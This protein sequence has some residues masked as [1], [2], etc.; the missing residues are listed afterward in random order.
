MHDLELKIDAKKCYDFFIN[1]VKVSP[2][3]M[4]KATDFNNIHWQLLSFTSYCEYYSSPHESYCSHGFAEYMDSISYWYGYS[5]FFWE[6]MFGREWAMC[7]LQRLINIQQD[8][9]EIRLRH[10]KH[11]LWGNVLFIILVVLLALSFNTYIE[12]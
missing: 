6:Q 7:Y 11:C 4:S 10:S 9:Q 8:S 5:R 3:K 2:Q 12:Y 1:V